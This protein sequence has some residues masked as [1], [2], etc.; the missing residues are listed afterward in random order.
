VAKQLGLKLG[1]SK[2]IF[3]TATDFAGDV[4]GKY[5]T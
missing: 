4:N 1:R 5:I 3:P 2:E